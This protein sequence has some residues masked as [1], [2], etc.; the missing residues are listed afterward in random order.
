MKLSLTKMAVAFLI[1]TLATSFCNGQTFV[2]TLSVA[3]HRY[4]T[5]PAV[6]VERSVIV[7]RPV[8]VARPIVIQRYPSYVPASPRPPYHYHRYRSAGPSVNF[9][10]R[11]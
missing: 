5:P 11:R 2:P 3:T 1:G 7:E 6:V 10:Y 8:V 9:H 4:N